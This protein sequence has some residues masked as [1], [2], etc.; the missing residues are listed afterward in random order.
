MP[1]RKRA[2]KESAVVIATAEP[3]PKQLK[4]AELKSELKKRGLDA[5]G[6]KSELVARLQEALEPPSKKSKEDTDVGRAVTAFKEE[7]AK[8][9]K[10]PR[11]R[12]VDKGLY[13]CA[14]Y[15]NRTD[16]SVLDEWDCMLNQTNIG[17]NNNKYYIIQLLQSKGVYGGECYFVWTRWGRVVRMCGRTVS[18]SVCVFDCSVWDCAWISLAMHM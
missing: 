17:Q 8:S 14:A 16:F 6:S 18:L 15:R 3:D 9:S 1:P 2:A 10:T 11:Q 5:T 12:K 13:D 4:V 7:A